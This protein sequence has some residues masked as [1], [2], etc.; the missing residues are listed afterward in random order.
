[1]SDQVN[2]KKTDFAI[3]KEN[4]NSSLKIISNKNVSNR[5]CFWIIFSCY[6]E[7]MIKKKKRNLFCSICFHIYWKKARIYQIFIIF[8]YV[9]INWQGWFPA[10]TVCVWLNSRQCYLFTTPINA[11]KPLVKISFLS[12][13]ANIGFLSVNYTLEIW[14]NSSHNQSSSH[15]KSL[16]QIWTAYHV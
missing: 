5:L 1:M 12:M 13:P 10:F 7:K 2:F 15:Q 14:L 9:V 3:F 11:R 6:Y 4:F 16:V 8:P